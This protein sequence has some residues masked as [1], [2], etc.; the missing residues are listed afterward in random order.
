MRL[1]LLFL[2]FDCFGTYSIEFWFLFCRHG[3]DICCYICFW[4]DSTCL[5]NF[6]LWVLFYLVS[7]IYLSFK[8][9]RNYWHRSFVFCS[10]CGYFRYDSLIQRRKKSEK[11][12]FSLIFKTS[13]SYLSQQVRKDRP[14]T[15]VVFSCF[16]IETPVFNLFPGVSF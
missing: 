14:F 11:K 7:D 16:Y 13:L 12:W 8:P 15:S 3:T 2:F 1:L 5:F 9:D 6:S 10:L 4:Y